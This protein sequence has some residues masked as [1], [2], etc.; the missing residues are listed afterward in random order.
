[1]AKIKTINYRFFGIIVVAALLAGCTG[2]ASNNS[3]GEPTKSGYEF[4]SVEEQTPIFISYYNSIKLTPAQ[5]KIK[6]DAL[7]RM[8]APCCTDYSMA[9][10]C[11][12]CN[13]AKSTWGLAAH[14][15]VNEGYNAD[16]VED[17]ANTWIAFAYPNG[18]EGDACYEGRCGV[19]FENDGCGGM[20]EQLII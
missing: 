9:S 16:Q 15:I 20:T 6:N 11:C 1:M 7:S 19:E 2:G 13:F 12:P 5:E 17:A 8:P 10:C 3:A 18:Y 14:L 4:Y